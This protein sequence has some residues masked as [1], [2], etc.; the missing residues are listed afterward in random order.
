MVEN[1][2]QG[3]N[4]AQMYILA[5]LVV[6]F[7]DVAQVRCEGLDSQGTRDLPALPLNDHTCHKH[8]YTT[9]RDTR[10]S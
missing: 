5:I 2:S 7:A 9:N 1:C 6:V 10:S 4:G 3:P 8:T